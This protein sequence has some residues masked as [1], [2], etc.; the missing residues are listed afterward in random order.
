VPVGEDHRQFAYT[1]DVDKRAFQRLFSPE[2][3]GGSNSPPG[4]CSVRA[5]CTSNPIPGVIVP[6]LFISYARDNRA[7]VLALVEHL[8]IMGHDTWVDAALRG[9]QD[10]WHEIL[11][12]IADTDVVI[13]IY[14]SAAL[15]STA[16]GREFEWATALGKPVIPVAVE[17]PP[18][19]LP[20]R[21][22]RRQIIDYSQPADRPLAALQLQGALATLPPPPPLPDPLPEPP[23]APL[24]YL[25]DLIDEVTGTAPIDHDR[26]H[27]ILVRLEPALRSRDREERRGGSDILERFSERRDIFADVDRVITRLRQLVPDDAEAPA[28]GTDADE[29]S[30]HQ[31]SIGTASP[32]NDEPHLDQGEPAVGKRTLRDSGAASPGAPTAPA[33]SRTASL[34]RVPSGWSAQVT[35]PFDDVKR[36]TGVAVDNR[37]NVYVVDADRVLCLAAGAAAPTRLPFDG[38]KHPTAVAVD[39]ASHVYVTDRSTKRVLRLAAGTTASTELPFGRLND[40]SGIAVDTAGNVYIA[41]GTKVLCLAAGANAPTVLPFSGLKYTRGVAVDAAGAVYVADSTSAYGGGQGRVLQLRAGAST[42]TRL[43][44]IALEGPDGVAVD[45]SANVYITER[46]RVRVMGAG[47]ASLGTLPFKDLGG[48]WGVAVDCGGAVYVTAGGR[49]LKLAPL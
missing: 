15:N 10:W 26:Q 46:S 34:K 8:G 42:A 39:T 16:C 4:S 27:V 1:A 7:D 41:D 23:A 21:F 9:G 2:R 30:D 3:A 6:K 48:P 12:R 43:P 14:S 5:Y 44:F 33:Q 32:P 45:G 20:S 22:A 28:A 35:L 17:P 29:P 13:A 37:G 40:P 19:A 25:T 31:R 49:V 36:P 38:L 18:T 11:D 47:A 24:S